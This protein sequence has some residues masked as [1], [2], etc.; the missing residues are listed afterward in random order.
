MWR[1]F[2]VTHFRLTVFRQNLL[3]FW[4]FPPPNFLRVDDNNFETY[5]ICLYPM[6]N[7]YA[8]FV[9]IHEGTVNTIV[10]NSAY[11]YSEFS[12]FSRIFTIA[13]FFFFFLGGG[14]T[15]PKQ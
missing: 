11:A 6:R 3:K 1:R 8:N 10:C 12:V 15:A 9:A 5:I 7:L 4:G 14:S 13:K 2:E